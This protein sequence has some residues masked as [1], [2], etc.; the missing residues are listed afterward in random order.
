MANGRAFKPETFD[1]DSE[2]VDAGSKNVDRVNSNATI[3]I[4][5]AGGVVLYRIPCF[6]VFTVELQCV[7]CS[8]WDDAHNEVRHF[9]LFI[10]ESPSIVNQVPCTIEIL[11]SCTLPVSLSTVILNTVNKFAA[12]LYH[13]SI[14]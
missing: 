9:D 1:S 5:K 2:N 8:M 14:G 3:D 6:S 7:V 11:E 12:Y 4:I 10:R 13:S